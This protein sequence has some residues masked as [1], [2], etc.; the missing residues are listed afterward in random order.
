MGFFKLSRPSLVAK[1]AEE[2]TGKDIWLDNDDLR[3]LKLKDRTWTQFT[4][5]TFWF[6]AAATVSNWFVSPRPLPI[7]LRACDLLTAR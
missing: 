1:G 7:S 4:Y 5:F 3:P 2:V 6:S